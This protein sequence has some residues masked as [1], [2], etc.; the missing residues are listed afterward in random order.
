MAL[1]YG[2]ENASEETIFSQGL[3]YFGNYNYSPKFLTLI[4][5]YP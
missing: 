1:K 4:Y 3:V 5:C 2:E